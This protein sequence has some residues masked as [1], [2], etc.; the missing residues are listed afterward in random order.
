MVIVLKNVRKRQ[1]SYICDR[2]R[3]MLVKISTEKMEAQKPIR[4]CASPV[5]IGNNIKPQIK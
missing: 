4:Y 5:I 1:S 2:K 3:G